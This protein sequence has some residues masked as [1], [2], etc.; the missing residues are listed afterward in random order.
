MYDP[1]RSKT[2]IKSPY[3]K[4]RMCIRNFKKFKGK[5]LD[6]QRPSNQKLNKDKRNTSHNVS[7][8]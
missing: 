5:F 2:Y 7:I 1:C 8:E 6:E 4:K 3:K